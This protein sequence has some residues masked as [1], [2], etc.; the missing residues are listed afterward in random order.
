MSETRALVDG[1]HLRKIRA[2][3]TTG[4]G[5]PTCMRQC[6]PA[7]GARFAEDDDP[8]PHAVALGWRTGHAAEP[9]DRRDRSRATD[10]PGL[11]R[12]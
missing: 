2:G 11:D 1:L 3:E 8:L 12:C 5:S 7:A 10:A 4:C 9:G 6:V